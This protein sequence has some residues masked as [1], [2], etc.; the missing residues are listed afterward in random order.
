[1]YLILEQKLKEEGEDHRSRL[2]QK[3]RLLA[4]EAVT[5]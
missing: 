1:M 5:A 2:S 3:P 4:L